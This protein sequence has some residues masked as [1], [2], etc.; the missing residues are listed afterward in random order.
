MVEAK[1]SL[2][3]PSSFYSGRRLTEVDMVPFLNFQG[4]GMT[5]SDGAETLEHR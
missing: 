5:S 3:L 2:S 4:G 1:V